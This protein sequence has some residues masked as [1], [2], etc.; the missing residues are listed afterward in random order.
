M[1]HVKNL[2]IIADISPFYTQ[3]K[4]STVHYIVNGLLAQVLKVLF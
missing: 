1:V 4:V 3:I 2:T